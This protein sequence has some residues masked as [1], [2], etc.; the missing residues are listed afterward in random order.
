MRSAPTIEQ[1]D[2]A[3][4]V[5]GDDREVGAG[6]DRVLQRPGLE[7][8]VAPSGVDGAIRLVGIASRRPGQFL[9]LAWPISV[10]HECRARQG[11]WRG[12]DYGGCS[13]PAVG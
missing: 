3:L 8:C 4:L 12:D 13:S 1:L 10:N 9:L 11:A 7:Q 6:Q 2:D 5:G